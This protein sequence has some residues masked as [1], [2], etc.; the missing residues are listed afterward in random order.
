M[1]GASLTGEEEVWL[2]CLFQ[3]IGSFL[4]FGSSLNRKWFQSEAMSHSR[5]FTSPPHLGPTDYGNQHE[6]RRT[7][8]NMSRGPPLK[9]A[10]LKELAASQ[11]CQHF[12]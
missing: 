7:S 11:L 6:E 9:S 10:L 3:P 2:Q 8:Q 1:G 12:S 4:T 5:R